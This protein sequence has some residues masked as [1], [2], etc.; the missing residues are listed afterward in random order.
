[1]FTKFDLRLFVFLRKLIQQVFMNSAGKIP[2]EMLI[3]S[4]SLT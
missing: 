2:K 4:D 3:Y 1:M